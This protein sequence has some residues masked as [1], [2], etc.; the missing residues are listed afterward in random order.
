MQCANGEI[1]QEENE[2]VGVDLL[3]GEQQELPGD[4]AVLSNTVFDRCW[5]A[6]SLFKATTRAEASI[7]GGANA[8]K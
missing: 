7:S 6:A 4:V 8:M 2:L 3:L 5:V 1:S